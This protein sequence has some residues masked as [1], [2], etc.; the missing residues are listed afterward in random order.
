[1]QRGRHEVA[2]QRCGALGAL[3]S[4][5][6]ACSARDDGYCR[7]AA[8]ATTYRRGADIDPA[9]QQISPDEVLETLKALL[10]QPRRVGSLA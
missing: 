5:L 10:A 3:G 7:W 8:A 6:G 2:E 1:M 4:A 9:M